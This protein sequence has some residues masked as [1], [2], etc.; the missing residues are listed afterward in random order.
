MVFH[1]HLLRVYFK[2]P[3]NGM[4]TSQG[5]AVESDEGKLLWDFTIQT[6]HFIE[7]RRPNIVFLYKQQGQCEIID[8]AVSGDARI[9]EKEKEKLE[10]YQDLRGEFAR[11]WRVNV[12]VTHV[13]V[14]ATKER[15]WSN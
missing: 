10:K 2:A 7:H 12:T 5:R 11:L 6:D 1:E 8:I 14:G 15:A 3:V 4:K 9:E 13:V